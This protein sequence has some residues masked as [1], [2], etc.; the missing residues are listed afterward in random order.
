MNQKQYK[1]GKKHI[2]RQKYFLTQKNKISRFPKSVFQVFKAF[3]VPFSNSRIFKVFNARWQ[4]WYYTNL[5][6][7]C[8]IY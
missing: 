1:Y 7:I 4:P 8:L 6:M 2:C 5:V 3:K